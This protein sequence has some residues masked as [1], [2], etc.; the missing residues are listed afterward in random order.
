[1]IKL[2]ASDLDGTI[3][4]ADGSISE[5]TRQAFLAAR[6][7]GIHIVFVTGRPFRWLSPVIKAF[8]GIG[9]VICSNGA[10]LYDLE[11]DKVIWS[12]TLPASTAAQ[13]A[14]IILEHEPQAAFAAETTK[15]LHLGPGFADKHHDFG[16]QADLDL[17]GGAIDQEGIVKFLAR[18]P[19]LGID[20][21]YAAVAPKLEP[22]LSVTHSAF[23]VSLL[24]MAHVDI[25]KATTLGVYCQKLGI[26]PEE[27]MAFGDMPNDVQMLQFAGQGYAMASGHPAALACA[28]NV[29]PPLAEDGV[30]QIIEGLLS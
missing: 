1:M 22:L 14:A 25:H 21:F 17:E 10:L 30:A 11:A 9:T 24:E 18:S 28:K 13:A 29:A 8:G 12:Q 20:E 23:D 19:G 26:S 4:A 27:V 3:V 7:A 6:S 5:R 2:I 16:I 15:G